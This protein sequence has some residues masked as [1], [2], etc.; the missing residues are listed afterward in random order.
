MKFLFVL[1]FLLG[2]FSCNNAVDF[3]YVKSKVWSYDG[4]FKIGKGDFILFNEEEKL[5]ALKGDT[6]FYEGRPRAIVTSVNKK[7]FIMEV[8]SID[9][10]ETGIYR[11]TEESLQ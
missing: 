4:G 7:L 6:I 5:F 2:I 3:V 8:Q 10:R 9:G 11:N 1:I